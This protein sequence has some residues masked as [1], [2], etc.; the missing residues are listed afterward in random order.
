[1]KFKI[2]R[3]IDDSVTVE[4]YNSKNEKIDYEIINVKKDGLGYMYSIKGLRVSPCKKKKV[5]EGNE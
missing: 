3:Q 5:R 1:M 2:I 4:F